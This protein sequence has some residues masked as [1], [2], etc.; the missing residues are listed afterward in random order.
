[1]DDF[2]NQPLD[3]LQDGILI[4]DRS[5]TIRQTNPAASLTLGPGE[6]DTFVGRNISQFIPKEFFEEYQSLVEIAVISGEPVGPIEMEL[7]SS[8]SIMI[9]VR[10]KLGL[11][12][13]GTEQF[14]LLNI[15]D[16]TEWK[17][18]NNELFQMHFELEQSYW[19]TLDGWGRALELRDD[20]TEGH[21]RR[22]TDT[23]VNLAMRYGVSLQDI[24]HIRHGALLHDI[25]KM[26]IPDA[27]L[28]KPGPLTDDEWVVMRRHPVYALEL[29][30]P[31]PYLKP[32]LGI[33]YSHH[34]KWDG[35]GYPLGLKGNEIP[36]G[37]RLFAVVDVWDALLSDRPYRK[38]W[39]QEKVL[40]YIREKSGTHFDPDIVDVFL[41]LY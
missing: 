2:Q 39:P 13:R 8:R 1:M 21:T 12:N 31:I 20:E 16:I 30:K 33:P 6:S 19:G 28:L 22:V 40:N 17:S 35:S 41:R 14:I 23:T 36:L 32:S 29:L 3:L 7:L 15:H 24:Q 10:I 25:G 38:G 18:V 26:A 34:E 9:Q 11:L 5:G 4:Y 27:I 37:A